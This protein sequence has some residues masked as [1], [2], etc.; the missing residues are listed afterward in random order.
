M[1]KLKRTK[2]NTIFLYIAILV[3]FL[4]IY[5]LNHFFPLYTDDWV[6]SFVYGRTSD[7]V[8][9]FFDVL[10][11]QYCH[12]FTWGGRS[13]AHTI[14][15]YLLYLGESWGDLLNS[16]AYVILVVFIY[17]I[18][19]Y[20]RRINPLLF[21]AISAL[22]WVLVPELIYSIVWLTGSANYLWGC[23]FVVAFTYPFCMYYL[24]HKAGENNEK[25]IL[26]YVLF[27]LGGVVAGWTNENLV[28]GLLFFI[29]AFF[30]LL[31][32]EKRN[33]P[34]WAIIAFIGVVIGCCFMLLA[35]GNY[36]RNKMELSIVHGINESNFSYS[37]YFYRFVSVAKAYL[38]YGIV[39]T[40]IYLV[41]FVAYWKIGDKGNKQSVLRLSV[42]F[43]CMATISMLVMTAAPIFPERVW[44]GIIVLFTIATLLLYANLDFSY[45]PIYIFNYV[46]CITLV[47]FL[48]ISYSSTLEDTIRLRNVFDRR[49]ALIIKEKSKGKTDFIF[50]DRFEP[51]SSFFYI[52]KV[53]DL[54]HLE[55]DLWEKAYSKYWGINSVKI[56]APK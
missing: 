2:Y 27:F 44:F 45:K 7:R 30:A 47:V 32:Y 39:P 33:I 54:P 53:Y 14:A 41:S 18:A 56:E 48:V 35:P 13:V 55:G 51:Q 9:G 40:L 19:D 49:E 6:Y 8:A 17:F 43:F 29:V 16:I 31:K 3:T 46:V 21:M 34:K 10:E 15:Q 25:S 36:I 24:R 37:Y 11:S 26:K 20:R 52:Q 1:D 23:L 5:V 50:N 38:V 22:I 4:G 28:V 42:V 12:Y